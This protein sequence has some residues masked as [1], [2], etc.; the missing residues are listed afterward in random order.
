MKI[1]N[2]DF[3]IKDNEIII[4]KQIKEKINKNDIRRRLLDVE[5]QKKRLKYRNNRLIEE[6]N[7]LIAE[8]NELN[9]I[10]AELGLDKPDETDELDDV[11]EK[12]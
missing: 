8:E 5:R 1:T 12:I 2:R 4:T 9:N 6:Y 11:L 3:T 7:K 10:I